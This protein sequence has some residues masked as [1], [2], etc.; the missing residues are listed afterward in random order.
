[1]R[2]VIG[3]E[4]FY[5]NIS[6]V[7]VTAFNLASY[8]AD[9][10]HEVHIIAPSPGRR[11]YRE[12]FP[13]G[14]TVWRISS[15][16]NLFRKGFR[17]TVYPYTRVRKVVAALRPDI[18]HL[19]DPACIGC[20]LLREGRRKNIPIVLSHHFTLDYVLTY[21]WFLKPVHGFL[22]RRLTKAMIDFYNCCQYVI[23]PS[24]TVK[25]QLLEAGLKTAVSAVSN[26]VNLDRF[27]AYES[28]L[29]IRAALRLPPHP[30]VLYVGRMDPEKN[31]DTLI[32]AM[33]LVLARH[34]AHFLLC[35]GGNSLEAL[36]KRVEKEELSK[37]VTFYGPLEYQSK[38]LPKI[39][40]LASCFV[41]TSGMETQSIVTLEAMASGLPVIAARAG[42]LPELVDD[43]GNGFLF[44]FEDARDL[45]S[46]IGILLENKELR[47]RMGQRSLE[48][49]V[50]HNLNESLSRIEAIYGE[51][52]SRAQS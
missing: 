38:L 48:K 32:T 31:L 50:Q 19:Q 33:P 39:Y 9:K 46:K 41:I 16:S 1:M 40:Q 10:G 43:G 14:F 45:A 22:Q 4:S 47:Q 17:V 20:T 15:V 2:V 8:L 24:N 26:G 37:Y 6:G 25:E 42:A 49:V 44:R 29:S 7:S 28:P 30:I 13:N 11:S 34:K 27:F 51:V 3:S 23:C 5:P 12:K 18:I 35:G 52:V 21:L 36:K